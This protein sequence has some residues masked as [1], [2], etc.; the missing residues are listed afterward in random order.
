MIQ[1][2]CISWIN[3]IKKVHEIKGERLEPEYLEK[4]EHKYNWENPDE[5]Q[6]K[7]LFIMIKI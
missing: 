4:K 1:N 5:F 7:E 2:L 3:R 6:R